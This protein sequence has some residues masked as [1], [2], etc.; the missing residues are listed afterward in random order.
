MATWKET[1]LNDFIDFNPKLKLSKGESAPKISMDILEPYTRGINHYDMDIY[2]GGAKFQNGDTIMA[3]ITPCLENGKTARVSILPEGSVGF[4]STEYIVW[5]E[6]PGISDSMF[7][8]YLSIHPTIRRVA[9][10]AMSGTSGRRRVQQDVFSSYRI[11]VPDIITQKRIASVLDSFDSRI[12]HNKKI[13][14]NLEQQATA[15]MTNYCASTSFTTELG[16]IMRFENG[17]AFQS[18]SYLPIGKYRIITIKNVQ[19]GKIDSQGAAFIDDVPRNMKAGCFLSIGDSLLSLTGNV[20][21][22]GIVYENN[23]LL[24]QRVAKFVPNRVELLPWLYYYFRLPLMK[25]SLETIAKGTAQQ[26]LS[27]V[28]TLKLEVSFEEESAR[29]LSKVLQPMYDA[30]VQNSIESLRL[31]QL[32]DSLLPRLMSGELD[33]SDIDL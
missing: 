22:V 9:I 3:R 21:R 25:T 13:N 23:L 20:G 1:T 27:P 7:I 6:K 28:E 33:V 10:E 2:N 4:G 24:N 16:Q 26:N 30:E 8:Y 29:E 32:R 18:K 19:D 5:R 15:L 11:K 12:E 31:S 17:Y 14:N